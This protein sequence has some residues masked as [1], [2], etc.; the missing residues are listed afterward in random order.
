MSGYVAL[1]RGINVGGKHLIKMADLKCCFEGLGFGNVATYIQSGNVVFEAAGSTPSKLAS[2][3]ESAL[4]QAFQYRSWVAVRSHKQ[5]QQVVARAPAG[6]GEDPAAYL[7]DVIFLKAE[8]PAAEAIK[9]VRVRTEVDTAFAGAGVLYFSRLRARATQSY[10][11]RI[12][13]LSI[14]RGMTIRNWNTTT[15]LL[16]LL[17]ARKSA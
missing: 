3:I 2:Q 5:M 9:D 6:F 16:A 13:G 8:L 11:N 1:L 14:Y 17:D 15:K 7:C 12:M 10:L 4:A